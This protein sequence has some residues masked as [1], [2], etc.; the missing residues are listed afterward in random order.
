MAII[1]PPN[2]KTPTVMW[3][4][5][6]PTSS[7]YFDQIN[8]TT[9]STVKSP[10]QI[11]SQNMQFDALKALIEL[12]NLVEKEQPT[13]ADPQT[14]PSNRTVEWIKEYRSLSGLGL[15]EAKDAYDQSKNSLGSIE[16]PSRVWDRNN[17][18]KV[19]STSHKEA[20]EQVAK[21]IDQLVDIAVEKAMAAR[22]NEDKYK[23]AIQIM[24][25]L[26]AAGQ[27]DAARTVCEAMSKEIQ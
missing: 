21:I 26:F 12:A 4:G 8:Q 20:V 25:S 6:M 18:K 2:F 1:D 7:T 22:S 3:V 15:K 11:Q 10:A 24:A 27:V 19:A 9:S 23:G 14:W 17:P 5:D 13:V 16:H